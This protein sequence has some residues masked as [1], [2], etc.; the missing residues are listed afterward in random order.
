MTYLC[1]I[2]TWSSRTHPCET[3]TTPL[4]DVITQATEKGKLTIFFE[5]KKMEKKMKVNSFPPTEKQKQEQ[6]EAQ[7]NQSKLKATAK[8]IQEISRFEAGQ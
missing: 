5:M 2:S 6:Q 4:V 3:M 1:A 7:S 8:I